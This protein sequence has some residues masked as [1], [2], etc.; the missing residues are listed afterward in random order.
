[1]KSSVAEHGTITVTRY[2]MAAGEKIPMHTHKAN[3]GHI[4]ICANGEV[5]IERLGDFPMLKLKLLAGMMI[6]FGQDE[7]THEIVAVTDAIVFNV[8][9]EAI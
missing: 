5:S 7:Q 9:R 1:M 8:Y 6:D 2:E 4:T 3:Q